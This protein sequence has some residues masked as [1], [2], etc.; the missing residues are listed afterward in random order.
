MLTLVIASGLFLL[1]AITLLWLLSLLL[2][3]AS[4]VDVFWGLGFI[5]VYWLSYGLT[6]QPATTRH[7]LLGLL[8]T[9]WGA[10][11]ALHI[12][13]RNWGQSEDFRYARWRQQAGKTWWWR[14]YFN[15]FLLQGA[16]LWLVAWP[17]L[18]TLTNGDSQPMA[19]LDIMAL[20]LWV[21][22]FI[23]EAG[24]DWQLS[25]FKKDPANKGRLM[26]S[27]LW[28][29]TRHPNYFGDALVWWG[30]YLF[31]VAAGGWW[32]IFS[33]LL[34]TYLLRRVSGVAMLE[35][36]LRETKPGYAA[37]MSRTNA[38]FPGL[39]KDAIENAQER[40]NEDLST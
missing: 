13:R 29:Y 17:L 15:V 22:G 14:S 40:S 20:L 9:I 3:D 4:I 35:R 23:F 1:T 26:A 33:P 11:L 32:T 6:S 34:M 39:P 18:A 30:F 28:R 12:L 25:R 19:W 10:R 36:T 8:V 38:F 27:G 7:L 31:A 5:F 2:H 21:A 16:I 37:Y 24:G